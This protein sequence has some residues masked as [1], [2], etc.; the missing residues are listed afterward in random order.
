MTQEQPGIK[1]V[2]ITGASSGFGAATAKLLAEQGHKLVLL[3]RRNGRLSELKKSLKTDVHT[4][5][6]DVSV[7]SQVVNFFDKLPKK[8]KDIDVL[9]N[10]AGVAT[11]NS[12]AQDFKPDDWD[13]MVDTNIKGVLHMTRP[14]LDV[15]KERGSGMIINVGSCAAY[16]PY[17]GANVY[18]GTKA[19]VRQF[20][21]NL[22]TDLFGTGI[23]VT[24][25]EPGAAET[26][27]SVVR[28]KSEQKAKEYYTGWQPLT[29]EDVAGTI[30]WVI[31][32]PPHVN[33]DN[34]EIMPLDQ[35]YGGSALNRK[36]EG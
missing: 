28:F 15:M 19:F 29:P 26:E 1:T 20:S 12:P 10:N 7:R 9:M 21:R 33:I 17:R 2:L 16:L 24:T 13:R 8:F 23:K 18:G 35:T 11:D 27:F 22:R 31:N 4:A 30:V 32:Q 36:K 14:V 34:I 25:I 5:I 6:V 3:A